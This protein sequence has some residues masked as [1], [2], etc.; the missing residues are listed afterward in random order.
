[1]TGASEKEAAP[2]LLGRRVQRIILVLWCCF[3]VYGSF[4]PFRLSTDPAF[5]RSNLAKLQLFPFQGG[6]KNF[7]LPDVASNI[8]LFIPFGFLLSGS[9]FSFVGLSWVRSVCAS[10]AFGLVF[11][12]AIEFGQLFAVGRRSSGIDVEANVIGALL[13]AMGACLLHR[14]DGQPGT[15]LQIAHDEHRLIP[16]TLVGLWLCSDAF[17]PFAVT[18]DVSTVWH[19]LTH[20]RWSLFHESQKF[21]LDRVVD[22]AVMFAMLSALVGSALRRHLSGAV[23]AIT[24]ASAAVVF[25]GGLEVGKLFVVGR[26]PTVA[27]VLLASVGAVL[28]VTAVPMLVEW[29]PVREHPEWALTLLALALLVYSELTPFA[30]ALSSAALAAHFHRIEWIPFLSYYGADPQGV[31]FDLWKKLLLSGF[32]GFSFA[33]LRGTTPFG[34]AWAGLLLGA[35]LETAQLLTVSRIPGVGDVLSF[36]LGA[37]IGGAIYHAAERRNQHGE[38]RYQHA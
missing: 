5:V 12:A 24:G 9:G 26:S 16:I 32:W 33:Q 37:W 1:V 35:L 27:N 2:D 8:L 23:A 14:Y 25:S 20:A 38:R 11:A 29:R 7:S 10:G 17:Y 36:G 28:G 19:N 30:F 13:G 3:I 4:I 21:W 15:C 31:V 22:E 6:T 34:A 18:L